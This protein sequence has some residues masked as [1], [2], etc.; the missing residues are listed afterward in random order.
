MNVSF[1]MDVRLHADRRRSMRV[2]SVAEMREIERRAEA[3]YGL[4]SPMLMERAGQSVAE[5]LRSHAGGDGRDLD[6]LILVGPGNNGGDGRVMGRYLAEWGARVTSFVWKENILERAGQAIPAGDQLAAL[7]EALGSADIVVD[8]FLGT[9]HARPLAPMMRE[10]LALTQAER[11]RRLGSLIVLAVDLPSGLNA[12][13]GAVDDGSIAADLTVTL[14]FPK[15]GLYLFP[16]AALVGELEVG[17]IGLP[18]E[19][20]I[21]PGMEVL[22]A[23]MVRHSLPARPL[24]SNKGTFGKAMILAGSPQYVGAAYLAASAAGRIG[25]GLITIATTRDLVPVYASCVVEA[26]YCLLPPLDAKPQERARVLFDALRGYRALVVGPGLGQSDVIRDFL[27]R[28]FDGVR[29]LP[30]S[31]RPRLLVDADGLNNLARVERWH[32]RLPAGTVLTPHPGEMARLRGG[33]Q[34]SGGGVD[35]LAVATECAR[36]WGHVVV[37]KGACTL[38]AAPDG[39]LRLNWPGNPA[40]ATA[41]TGDALAGTIGGLLAQGMAPFEAAS[42][43]VYLHSRAGLLVSARLGDAGLLASDLLP[44]LPLALR[45]TKDS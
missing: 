40:L 32:E 44:E 39:A 31:E 17:S 14:A 27:L 36:A 8:A 29:A 22:D 19:M 23:P 5:I 3:E 42:A 18:E 7:R 37:L 38:V 1:G 34:V 25:A 11:E 4:T 6:V 10:A 9:G 28:V 26:T 20:P 15:I 43:G 2:V 45:A 24:E 33:A 13:T 16:G 12:D 30:E 35:R 41:G 21:A